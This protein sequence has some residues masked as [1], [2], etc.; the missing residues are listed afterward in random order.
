MSRSAM[1][2]LLCLL[3]LPLA[4]VAAQE[5]GETI[6]GKVDID[7]EPRKYAL[8][9]PKDVKKGETLPLV[10]AVPGTDQAAFQEIGEWELDAY[11]NRFCVLS[12]DCVTNTSKGWHP[13]EAIPMDK[14]R[15]AVVESLAASRKSAPIDETAIVITGWSGGT[16]LTLFAGIRHPELFLAVC[17]RSVVFFPEV[18]R[19]GKTERVTP[20]LD[21]P[22]FLCRGELDVSRS[23]KETENAANV[24]KE[25]GFR[26]VT[27]RV[28]P[29]MTHESKREVFLEWFLKLLKE[30]EKARKSVKGIRKE[31]AAL[32]EDLKKGLK[33]GFCTKL[34]AILDQEKKL[35]VDAGGKE[36][37]ATVLVDAQKLWEVAATHEAD[38]RTAEAAAAYKKIEETYRP[39]EI[40]KRAAQARAKLKTQ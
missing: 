14:D 22:V 24:L 15:R 33:A 1:R 6:R 25:G 19:I 12:I 2:A 37:L 39:L 16:Y 40:A 11:K 20:N 26:A 7:G 4:R 3:A 34:Q 31:V 38:G 18:G 30:T 27:F 17:A 32:S 23:A 29:K 10:V 21:Q 8:F 5:Y 35:G 36:L 28:I 9:V 13:S